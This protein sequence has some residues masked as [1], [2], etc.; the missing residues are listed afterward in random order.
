MAGGR[1]VFCLVAR[2]MGAD[3]FLDTALDGL[4]V[5]SNSEIGELELLVRLLASSGLG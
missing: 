5:G 1:D 3:D 4:L 2:L